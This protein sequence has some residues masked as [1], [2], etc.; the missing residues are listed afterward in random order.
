MRLSSSGYLNAPDATR[1]TLTADGWLKTGDI[2]VV[3]DDAY[4]YIVD[5]KKELI[6]YN[7]FQGISYTLILLVVAHFP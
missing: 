5:R 1:D 6:K 4:F 3:D 2:A 7:A